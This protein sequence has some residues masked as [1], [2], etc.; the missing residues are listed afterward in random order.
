MTARS[1]ACNVHGGLFNVPGELESTDC[2]VYLHSETERSANQGRDEHAGSPP[3]L[4]LVICDRD[5][6]RRDWIVPAPLSVVVTSC[7]PA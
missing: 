4:E 6:Q 5:Y 7:M 3:L 1:T 2:V